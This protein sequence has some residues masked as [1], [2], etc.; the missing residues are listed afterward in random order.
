[1]QKCK[2][3]VFLIILV[4]TCFGFLSSSVNAQG[5]RGRCCNDGCRLFRHHRPCWSRQ[6]CCVEVRPTVCDCTCN[7]TFEDGV[8]V[9][10][11]TCSIENCYCKKPITTNTS[12]T[13]LGCWSGQIF[14]TNTNFKLLIGTIAGD[15]YSLKP[16][17]FELAGGQPASFSMPVKLA[18]PIIR[19][20]DAY[21]EFWLITIH[22]DA[23]QNDPPTHEPPDPIPPP[24]GQDEFIVEFK[25]NGAVQTMTARVFNDADNRYQ[26]TVRF[27]RFRLEMERWF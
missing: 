6:Q 13:T 24:P 12:G 16:Y 4:T 20:G 1:M 5:F 11:V 3:V 8:W 18:V 9:E 15:T 21:S 27:G 26:K 17:W 19:M 22:Y 23:A 2:L 7:L 25:Y 14:T 10:K